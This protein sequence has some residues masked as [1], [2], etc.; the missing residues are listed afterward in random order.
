VP[1]FLLALGAPVQAT[2]P[3]LQKYF[4]QLHPSA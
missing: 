3:Q 2:T 1:I 4:F